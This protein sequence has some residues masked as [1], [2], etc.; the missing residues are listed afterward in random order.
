VSD[1]VIFPTAHIKENPQRM[2]GQG[3]DLR[4]T[5]DDVLFLL[6]LLRNTSSPLTTSQLLEA[7]KQRSAR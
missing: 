3:S 1:T 7:L 5:D 4:L 2:A 6:T